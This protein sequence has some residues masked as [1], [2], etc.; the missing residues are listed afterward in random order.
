MGGDCDYSPQVLK[1][2]AMPLYR[3]R[4]EPKECIEC[5]NVSAVLLVSV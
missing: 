5:F 2:L 1:Y 4:N 3:I